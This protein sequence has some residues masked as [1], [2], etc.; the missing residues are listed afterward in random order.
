MNENLCTFIPGISDNLLK[1]IHQEVDGQLLPLQA[2]PVALVL[3]KGGDLGLIAE[4]RK[5][6]DGRG[7]VDGLLQTQKAAVGQE[8]LH[9]RVSCSED[10]NTSF[11]RFVVDLIVNLSVRPLLYHSQPYL[12]IAET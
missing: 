7:V 11:I 9:V 8:H 1:G 2:A 12:R 4:D 10:V 3:D 5:G 6:Q